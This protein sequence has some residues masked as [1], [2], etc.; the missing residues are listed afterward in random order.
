M[1]TEVTLRLLDIVKT[2]VIPRLLYMKTEVTP[3]LLDIVMQIGQ[4]RLQVDVPLQD[5]VYLL[6]AI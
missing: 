3:K 5:I 2:E 6:E 1:K 4:A